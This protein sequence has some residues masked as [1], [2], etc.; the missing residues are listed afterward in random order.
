MAQRTHNISQP[1]NRLAIV[2]WSEFT[3]MLND[4][5][6]DKGHQIAR[7]IIQYAKNVEKTPYASAMEAL[8]NL[9]SLFPN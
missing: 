6:S 2:F 3:T 7:I 5:L 9:L 1:D 8:V 4:R